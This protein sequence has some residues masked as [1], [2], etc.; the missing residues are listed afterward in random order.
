MRV[1]D[2]AAGHGLFG[3][4]VATQNP[5]A[6][7][8]AVDWAA[9]SRRRQPTPG[10]PAWRVGYETLAGSAFDVDY[11][12]PYD[13]ALLRI[14]A[15]LRPGNVRRAADEGAARADAR[16]RAATPTRAQRRPGVASDGCG[17]CDDM[18]GTTAVRRRY[19]FR[20]YEGRSRGG[21]AI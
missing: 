13:V 7:I 1:L 17:V 4:G 14:S 20:E 15:P 3:I 8:V 21:S 12:G 5:T 16:G 6:R 18:L 2:I 9:S 11:G 10:R 19:T